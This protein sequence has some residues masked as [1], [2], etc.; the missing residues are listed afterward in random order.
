MTFVEPRFDGDDFVQARD[1]KRLVS[2]MQA[3]FD[4]M[5]DEKWRSVPEIAKHL[6]YPEASVSAQL[7]NLRKPRL[8][9]HLVNRKYEGSGLYLFQLIE[10]KSS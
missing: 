9:G 2:Q 5:R 1:G 3:I 8:G 10:R 6:G 4:H 7:R